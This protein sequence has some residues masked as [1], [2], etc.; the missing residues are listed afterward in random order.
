MPPPAKR[1]GADFSIDSKTTGSLLNDAVSA[2]I[3]PSA[4][5]AAQ[6]IIQGNSPLITSTANNMPQSKN[7]WCT[8]RLIVESTSALIIA[9][10]ILLIISNKHKP[11]AVK[12]IVIGFI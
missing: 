9:L 5:L 11:L 8:R 2:L 10:S 7:H 1:I 6:I 4:G 3:G 12:I